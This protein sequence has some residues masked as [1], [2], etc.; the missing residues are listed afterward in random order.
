MPPA[1]IRLE[2]QTVYTHV[3]PGIK[4]L[5]S[6]PGSVLGPGLIDLPV[7]GQ[8]YFSPCAV[9]IGR[10]QRGLILGESKAPAM[11]EQNPVWFHTVSSFISCV[12][13]F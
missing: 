3:F 12:A 6:F 8:R 9:V 2:T 7:V 10:K 4:A 11:G 1:L 13:L 5:T